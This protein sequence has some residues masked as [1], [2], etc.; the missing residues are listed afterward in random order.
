MHPL[1]LSSSTSDPPY[2]TDKG[3]SGRLT[4]PS[5]LYGL[6]SK[7][8]AFSGTT[9]STSPNTPRPDQAYNLTLTRSEKTLPSKVA[10]TSSLSLLDPHLAP[11]GSPLPTFPLDLPPQPPPWPGLPACPTPRG[12]TLTQKMVANTQ[13]E[14]TLWSS[15][16][17][18]SLPTEP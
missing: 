5:T 10:C 13:T 17:P 4:R 7:S 9:R 11:T 14:K 3:A 2:F 12:G 18:P 16:T 1:P 6:A 8:P 15:L